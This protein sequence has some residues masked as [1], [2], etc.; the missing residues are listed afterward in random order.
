M[1]KIKSFIKNR[2]KQK[3]AKQ[4]AQ[5]SALKSIAD[6]GINVNAKNKVDLATA[7][8]A[9]EGAAASAA[10]AMGVNI[11]KANGEIDTNK[12]R[13]AVLQFM[14]FTPDLAGQNRQNAS[15]QAAISSTIDFAK[16]LNTDISDGEGG[17]DS[18]KMKA[19][20]N[21]AVNFDELSPKKRNNRQAVAAL[22]SSLKGME[23][24]TELSRR[25]VSEKMETLLSATAIEDGQ[26]S[27]R[28]AIQARETLIDATKNNRPLWRKG[29]MTR[30]EANQRLQH[31]LKIQLAN[32]RL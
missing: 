24:M 32:H 21:L 26:I 8:L 11:M 14:N 16:S 3:A 19:M 1:K 29:T 22:E 13:E 18:S 27:L 2:Q 4:K 17:I 7:R 9:A 10:A 15:A 20:V 31:N 5:S 28:K 12:M 25:E 6:L 23:T 30:Q